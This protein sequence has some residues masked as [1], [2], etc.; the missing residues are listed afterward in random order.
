MN[1]AGVRISALVGAGWADVRAK[2]GH[3]VRISLE[4]AQLYCIIA[5]YCSME[6][7]SPQSPKT[8]NSQAALQDAIQCS[9]L[10]PSAVDAA[11]KE[12]Q[13]ISFFACV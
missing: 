8:P 7:V 4:A 12:L 2:G 3:S 9:G 11:F 10:L 6:E 1:F 13:V 5:R